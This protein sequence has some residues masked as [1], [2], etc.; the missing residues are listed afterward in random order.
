MKDFFD[1]KSAVFIS[2]KCQM[3]IAELDKWSYT[4]E[5][6]LPDTFDHTIDLLLYIFANIQISVRAEVDFDLEAALE[7]GET[8]RLDTAKDIVRNKTVN[9]DPFAFLGETTLLDEFEGEMDDGARRRYYFAGKRSDLF[10]EQ[11]SYVG[12]GTQAYEGA[13]ESCGETGSGGEE[14]D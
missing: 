3:L 12:L 10:E 7:N 8:V 2:D 1:Q 9:Q 4:K 6:K 14:C 13:D 5:G 11:G